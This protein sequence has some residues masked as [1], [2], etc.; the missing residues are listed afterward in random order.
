MN[1]HEI[2]KQCAELINERGADYGRIEQNFERI[3]VIASASTGTTITPY[4]ACMVLA[5]TK[6]ARMSGSRDKADNY[7]DAI[8][9]LSFAHEL[10]GMK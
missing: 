7:I 1:P 9:Y 5:A 2:L 6:L 10:R 3:A 4:I 8:N